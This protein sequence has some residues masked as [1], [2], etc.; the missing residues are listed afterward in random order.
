MESNNSK[1]FQVV[2]ALYKYIFVI[3]SRFSSMKAFF[4]ELGYLSNILN[5]LT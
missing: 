2:G 4:K 3:A 5:P 1:N